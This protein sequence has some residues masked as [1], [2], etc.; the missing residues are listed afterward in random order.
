MGFSRQEHW[1]G[2]PY[3]PPGDL[4][5]LGIKPVS[6]MS[7]ALAS[8][9]FTTSTSWEAPWPVYWSLKQSSFSLPLLSLEPNYTQKK[10][11]ISPF[12]VKFNHSVSCPTLCD[13]MNRSTQSIPVHHQLP[14][15]TQILVHWVGD[16]IQPSHPVIPF[17]SCP[18]SFPVSGSFQMS[19]LSASGGQSVGPFYWSPN[20]TSLHT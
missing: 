2:L 7:P 17:S 16:A 14:G 13:P 8:R 3:T 15:S 18:Q 12:S 5:N 6:P 10:V 20:F 9:F 19:Q 11:V 4:P 1:S